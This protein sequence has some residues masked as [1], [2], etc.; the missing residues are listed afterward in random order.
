MQFKIKKQYRNQKQV[1]FLYCFLTWNQYHYRQLKV[2]YESH[3]P[4]Q[5]GAF[6]RF[7]NVGR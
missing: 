2:I 1:Y 3:E 5:T 6:H 4:I 7:F